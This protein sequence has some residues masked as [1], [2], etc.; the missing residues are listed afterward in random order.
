M[1]VVVQDKIT[2]VRYGTELN[3]GGHF[4]NA[5]EGAGLQDFELDRSEP[6]V[7]GI[8]I[9]KDSDKFSR[10]EVVGAV[11]NF[12][13]TAVGAG[14]IAVPFALHKTGFFVGIF[15]ILVAASLVYSGS[16]YLVKCGL[17]VG[18]MDYSQ[19][20]EVAFGRIGYYGFSFMVSA[21]L[22]GVLSA[23]MIIIGDNW[24]AFAREA[25]LGYFFESR[26]LSTF[27]LALISCKN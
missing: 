15:L 11:A 10:R 25:N 2:N 27:F 14:V 19:I 23:Y 7:K 22:F 26:A 16:C 1:A 20:M 3:N 5:G 4:H 12:V 8:E 24:P 17:K 9:Q 18:T 21:F 6:S 13:N